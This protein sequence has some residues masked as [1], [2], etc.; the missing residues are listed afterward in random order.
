MVRDPRDAIVSKYYG[1]IKMEPEIGSISEFIL[2]SQYLEQ[3]ISLYNSWQTSKD[4]PKDFLLVRYEDMIENAVQELSRVME[5]LGLD[6]ED[7]IIQLAVEDNSF[8]KMR[9]LEKEGKHK[10]SVLL[11]RNPENPDSYKTRKRK[12]WQL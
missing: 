2:N 11:S 3:Y 12:S 4:V 9:N 10:A 5:F 1:H 7:K 6:I 8:D